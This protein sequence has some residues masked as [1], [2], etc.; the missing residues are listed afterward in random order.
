MDLE[1]AIKMH[2]EDQRKRIH[3]TNNPVLNEYVE[4]QISV[5]EKAPR[6]VE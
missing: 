6:V 3:P 1:T 5:I 2:L 4:L